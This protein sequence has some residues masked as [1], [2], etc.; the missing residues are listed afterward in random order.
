MESSVDTYDSADYYSCIDSEEYSHESPEEALEYFLDGQL[1]PGCD[2]EA[3]IRAC[4]PV[5][6]TGF[7]RE[8]VEPDWTSRLSE[9]LVDQVNEAWSDEYGNP[10]GPGL[11]HDAEAFLA[12]RF[13]EALDLIIAEQTVWACDECGARTYSVEEIIELMKEHRPDWFE[14]PHESR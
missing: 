5:K 4:G 11:P 1:D 2:T 9:R 8:A 14:G 10:D 7:K 3:V 12:T 6:V 13:K